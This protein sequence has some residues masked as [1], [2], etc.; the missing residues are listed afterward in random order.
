MLS[1]RSPITSS[2][3]SSRC[4]TKRGISRE[5]VREVGVGHHD[6]AAAGGGEAGQV[7][8]AVA[9]PR[10]VD[11]ARAGGGGQLGAAVLGRVVGDDDLAGDAVL[12]HH[13]ERACVTQRSMFSS[14]LRQ[15]ITT[16]TTSSSSSERRGERGGGGLECAHG[17]AGTSCP[18][19]SANATRNQKSRGSRQQGSRP[20]GVD[21]LA[22]LPRRAHL[23]RLRLPV[24][25]HRRRRRALVPQPRAAPRGRR[26]RRHLPHAAPVAA[27]RA[28]RDPG[29]ARRRRRAADGALRRAAASAGSCRRWCSA[30]ACSGTCC[31]T[32]AATTSCTPRSFPYFSLLAAALLRPLGRYRLVVDWFELWSGDVLARVPRAA[33]AAASGAPCRRC[34]C[35]CASARSAS[36]S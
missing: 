15:G 34:A 14:S 28:R 22:P 18:D 31:A 4:S 25:L 35:G 1:I 6:V 36:P 33:S 10:L 7:G 5:V 3:P 27:R 20:L 24:P 12:G 11:D 2:A 17:K 29:R 21:R 9:A 32:A 19:A 26:P 30:P 13:L 16:E 23:H 8:A